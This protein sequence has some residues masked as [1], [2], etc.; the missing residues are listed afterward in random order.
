MIDQRRRG[1]VPA[2][3]KMLTSAKSGQP[4]I[5]AT[6]RKRLVVLIKFNGSTDVGWALLPVLCALSRPRV[7]NLR[8]KQRLESGLRLRLRSQIAPAAPQK[9]LLR[10]GTLIGVSGL[11]L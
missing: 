3:L 2:R 5:K 11:F 10:C 1:G 7:A 4:T 8:L 6:T 9:T